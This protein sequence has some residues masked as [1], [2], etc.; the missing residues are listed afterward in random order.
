MRKSAIQQVR[1]SPDGRTEARNAVDATLCAGLAP[2]ATRV[3]RLPDIRWGVVFRPVNIGGG[4]GASLE[5]VADI[6]VLDPAVQVV[7]DFEGAIAETNET[8]NRKDF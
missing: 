7:A 2:G 5:C 4:N 8:N 1:V 3:A 6:F